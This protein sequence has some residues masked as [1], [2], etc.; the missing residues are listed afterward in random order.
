[1]NN[2]IVKL[3]DLTGFQHAKLVL[4]RIWNLCVKNSFIFQFLH[5]IVRHL[6]A[7]LLPTSL[8]KMFMMEMN[9]LMRNMGQ[10]WSMDSVYSVTDSTAVMWLYLKAACLLVSSSI[11]ITL[12]ARSLTQQSFYYYPPKVFFWY[13]PWNILGTKFI[14][15]K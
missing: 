14:L 9:K 7:S 6:V 1:M 4:L 8:L 15:K 5:N 10:S 2:F 12:S 13:D 11:N 3:F